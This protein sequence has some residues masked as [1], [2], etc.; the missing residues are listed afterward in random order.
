MT[1]SSARNR[2]ERIRLITP[3]ACAIT[4]AACGSTA[5]GEVVGA[6]AV[7]RGVDVD[8]GAL[9]LPLQPLSAIATARTDVARGATVGRAPRRP[10]DGMLARLCQPPQPSVVAAA[11]AGVVAAAVVA[12]LVTG[13]LV[14]VRPLVLIVVRVL[15]RVVGVVVGVVGVVGLVV[16]VVGLVCLVVGPVSGPRLGVTRIGVVVDVVGVV[17]DVFLLVLV[18]HLVD[19]VDVA[20]VVDRGAEPQ[21]GAGHGEAQDAS[22]VVGHRW[23]GE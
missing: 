16:G 1:C 8:V 20:L 11:V 22:C 3:A 15:C 9:E 4:L 13:A 7:D 18:L 14:V 21:P 5:G 2:Q 6:P 19:V 12:G 23:P 10:P 17:V